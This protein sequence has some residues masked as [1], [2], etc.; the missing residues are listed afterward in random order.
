MLRP[1]P[2]LAP[3]LGLLALACAPEP[4]GVEVSEHNYEITRMRDAHAATCTHSAI[5]SAVEDVMQDNNLLACNVAIG[6][7]DDPVQM[8]LTKHL[9]D[10][11]PA[12]DL[13]LFTPP[14]HHLDWDT[15]MNAGSVSKLVTAQA[16]LQL[17]AD[18]H[19]QSSYVE[20]EPDVYE[21]Q[22]DPLDSILVDDGL[23]LPDDWPSW[24]G[25]ITMKEL[26]SHTSGI[27]EGAGHWDWYD[28]TDTAVSLN[29]NWDTITDN[30]A[31]LDLPAGTLAGISAPGRHPR[32]AYRALVPPSSADYS[33]SSIGEGRYSNI[34]YLLLGAIIDRTVTEPGF[35]GY[36]TGPYAVGG[37]SGLEAGFESYAWWVASHGATQEH[38]S[39][40]TVALQTDERV[41]NASIP[42]IP[43]SYIEK[44]GVLHAQPQWD[45][46]GFEG[47]AGGWTMTIGDQLRLVLPLANAADS[48]MIEEAAKKHGQAVDDVGGVGRYGYGSYRVTPSAN[49][50]AYSIKG[51]GGNNHGY[52]G[53]AYFY[54]KDTTDRLV[55]IACNTNPQTWDGSKWKS[56]VYYND[57]DAEILDAWGSTDP[58]CTPTPAPGLTLAQAQVADAWWPS[59]SASIND[60]IARSGHAA[61][62]TS[63]E[64][65]LDDGRSGTKALDAVEDGDYTNAAAC[66]L[67]WAGDT[68][69]RWGCR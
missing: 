10:F 59:W 23:D 6:T 45:G 27:Y 16:F 32:F 28:D 30:E 26:L 41:P 19:V 53:G 14:G 54:R 57:M 69:G 49:G 43:R 4:G 33:Y 50:N 21:L 22:P 68:S 3:A 55:A 47:P 20:V 39:L 15:P 18:N 17:W 66:A 52:T 36:G 61:T 63:W 34:N 13:P 9:V 2:S 42:H 29:S 37:L 44:G 12:E 48:R 38:D 65:S 25:L 58:T 62:W 1:L 51:H 24:V 11:T 5:E 64:R 7:P 67:E 60:S 8:I 56:V 40:L 35:D 31:L 46:S